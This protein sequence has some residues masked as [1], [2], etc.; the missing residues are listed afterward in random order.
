MALMVVVTALAG[1]QNVTAEDESSILFMREEEKLARDVYEQLYET[2]GVRVFS[3]IARAEQQHM[4]A[5]LGLIDD[6]DLT[7]P[8]QGPGDFANEE[9]QELYDDLVERGSTSLEEALRVGA[10]VEEVDIVDLIESLDKTDD[11]QIAFVYER[12]LE[13]SYNHLRAFVGQ[14]DRL[15]VTY[16]PAVLEEGEYAQ[17]VF[18]DDTRGGRGRGR[19]R[20]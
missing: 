19:G 12:L 13:G 9:L 14:L 1:A 16:E 3:N 5:V 8:V 15:G 11:A 6:Y 7:D 4:N 10:L 2:W 18:D 20:S 17:I